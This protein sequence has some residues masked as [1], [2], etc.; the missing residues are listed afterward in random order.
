MT[1]SQ[2]LDR[3]AA[4]FPDR[5]LVIGDERSL[6]YREVQERSRRLA[7]GLVELGVGRGDHVALVM[8]DASP[9]AS[10]GRSCEWRTSRPAPMCAESTVRSPS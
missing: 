4:E 7:A 1:L 10:P 6:T 5:P 3:A 2:T 9:G 8:A